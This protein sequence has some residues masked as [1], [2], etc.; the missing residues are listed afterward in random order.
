M[1][2]I[3]EIS[4]KSN[5]YIEKPKLTNS[6]VIS[7][8]NEIHARSEKSGKKYFILVVDCGA[9]NK[10]PSAI[11]EHLHLLDKNYKYII[12]LRDVYPENSSSIPKMRK[13][14]QQT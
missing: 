7:N 12:G 14:F 10:V 3:K 11:K 6:F 13:A 2:L 4:G 8:I 1:S 9:D 5:V